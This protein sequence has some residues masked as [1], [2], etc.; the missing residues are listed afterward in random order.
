MLAKRRSRER[1]EKES[2]G[3]G[4]KERERRTEWTSGSLRRRPETV[5]RERRMGR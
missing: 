5:A 2:D 4:P 3:V 1:K